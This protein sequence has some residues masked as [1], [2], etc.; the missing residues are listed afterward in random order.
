[1]MPSGSAVQRVAEQCQAVAVDPVL[2]RVP[3]QPADRR[4]RVDQK[5]RKPG[6]GE[7]A[8]V[9]DRHGEAAAAQNVR[10]KPIGATAARGPAAAV[11]ENDE[12]AFA[13]GL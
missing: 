2:A 11:E 5:I 3:M 8:V 7:Q 6:F 10:E 12:A 13:R 1:M 9:R 4:R